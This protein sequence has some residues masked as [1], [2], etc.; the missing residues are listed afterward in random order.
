MYRITQLKLDIRHSQV[1]LVKA[2]ADALRIKPSDI[3]DLRVFKRSVDAR[4]K[5]EI[6]YVYTVDVDGA[7]GGYNLQ[8]AWSSGFVAGKNAAI[9]KPV[10]RL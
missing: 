5:P 1:D 3:K 6:F 10:F 7:C 9:K 4:K 2:A 8:W